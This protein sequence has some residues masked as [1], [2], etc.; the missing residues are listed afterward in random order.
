VGIE[1]TKVLD[2]LSQLVNKS[3]VMT[4]Q[5]AGEARYRRLDS[6]RQYACEKLVESGQQEF[7]RSQHL[8]YFLQ[9]S[10]RAETALRGP[11]QSEWMSRLNDERDNIYFALDWAAKHDHDVEA[12]L[13]LAGR[14]HVFWEGFDIR[15]GTRWLVAFLE[16]PASKLHPLARAK[17]LLAYGWL[18]QW[19]EQFDVGRS[20]AQECLE[21]YKTC[22][23]QR[24]VA[25]A[26]GLLAIT[27]DMDE[28]MPLLNQALVI[29]QTL[30]DREQQARIL[31]ARL[32][33]NTGLEQ[34]K[35]DLKEAV[36]LLREA[37]HL[38]RLGLT[39]NWLAQYEMWSDNLESAEAYL[40]E[41]VQV[42]KQLN[43]SR[44]AEQNS[45]RYG[46]LEYLKGNFQMARVRYQ[47]SLTIS[48]RLGL[49]MGVLWYHTLLAY[50]AVHEGDLQKAKKLFVET[51]ENFRRDGRLI[52]VVFTL[53][54]MAELYISLDKPE[55][56]ACLIGWADA[57]REKIPDTRPPVEER[58]VDHTITKCLAAMGEIGFTHAYEEGKSMTM[59]QAITY[60]CKDIDISEKL[61]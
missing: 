19:L 43:S 38:Q 5:S 17:A 30:G 29:A 34:G 49:R 18:M 42:S 54:G 35:S 21:I 60:A 31:L 36:D 39:L 40:V 13:Y 46:Q 57:M 23:D 59:D 61:R 56:A 55:K 41:A 44:L 53:E 11:S 33:H 37:G 51:A 14:L 8:N 47:E 50:V 45:A 16:K 7:F 15:E 22:D 24:G 27:L 58:D 20:S 26:I 25:D 6:I 32:W 10:E 28:A 2:L 52:G 4:Q 9:L 48:E 1:V 12:G 3:L